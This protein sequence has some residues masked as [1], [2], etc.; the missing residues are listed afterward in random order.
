M[1]AAVRD[2]LEYLRVECGSARNTALAYGRDL[3]AL[4]AFLAGRRRAVETA[5]GTDLADFLIAEHKRG[6]A[7]ASL[8]R[9]M[10][11]IRMLYRFLVSEGRVARDP[12]GILERPHLGRR[13]PTVLTPGEVERLLAAPEGDAPL[14]VRDRAALELLYAAGARASELAALPVG[15]VNLSIGYA[16]LLGKGGKERIVPVGGPAL[17]AIERYL[18]E[19]RPL[20]AG[21]SAP[22]A[23]FLSRGGR[24]LT[25]D[26]VWRLVARAAKKA[27]LTKRV[28][29]HAL[30]HAFATHL[31]TGGAHLRAVQEMLGHADVSTTEVYTHLD[32]RH[33][34][35][36]YDKYHPRA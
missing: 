15:A 9:R 4:E 29:P 7:A 18:A 3:G 12:A 10:A 32:I 19:A 17:R 6:L 31:V 27:G 20:L 11:A 34:R 1:A 14:A 26:A 36:V 22:D 25:R 33:L 5:R 28:Y 13:L 35:E 16:R 30:R 8:A 21:A 2:F 23:L 24:A